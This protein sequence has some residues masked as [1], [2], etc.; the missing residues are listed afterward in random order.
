MPANTFFLSAKLL[1]IPEV[2]GLV[3]RLDHELKQGLRDRL[4]QAAKI[5][6]D[7]AKQ[8]THSRRVKAAMGFSVEVK[9]L[10]DY[11]AVIGPLQRRAFFAHFLEFGTKAAP[12]HGATRAFPFL[13][14]ALEA[15]TDQVVDLVGV[16]PSLGGRRSP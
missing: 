13:V 12:G 7:E 2:T 15:T 4:K 5:V 8:R 6:S 14:P 11:Q 9:S 16:P 3:S 10:T 1:G